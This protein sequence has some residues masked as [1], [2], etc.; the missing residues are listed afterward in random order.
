MKYD[1]FLHVELAIIY[2]KSLEGKQISAKIHF[3]Y[4]ISSPE[5]VIQ[6]SFQRVAVV[7]SK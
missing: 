6:F 2:V 5:G 3:G 1:D 7:D 4:H